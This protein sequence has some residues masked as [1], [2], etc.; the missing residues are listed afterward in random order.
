MRAFFVRYLLVG[1][2][3]LQRR[4]RAAHSTRLGSISCLMSASDRFARGYASGAR[5]KNVDLAGH[6]AWPA[7]EAIATKIATLSQ[8]MD[9]SLK[10]DQGMVMAQTR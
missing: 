5:A 10:W 1:A 2:L 8:Q 6:S 4:K 9:K 3:T 7:R